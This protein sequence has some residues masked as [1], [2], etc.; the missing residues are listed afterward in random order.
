METGT[1]SGA[2]DPAAHLS[3]SSTSA[4]IRKLDFASK[5][6]DAE[7]T[8]PYR[9][10]FD[11]LAASSLAAPLG[12]QLLPARIEPLDG[13]LSRFQCLAGIGQRG[14]AGC[15]RPLHC[16]LTTGDGLLRGRDSGLDPLKLLLLVVAE[17][18]RPDDRTG[19]RR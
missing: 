9:Q 11:P 10:G 12:L 16:R 14:V 6:G 13:P 4:T 18:S 15:R 8:I 17:L 19:P 7:G 1:V 2:G 3:L 5:H